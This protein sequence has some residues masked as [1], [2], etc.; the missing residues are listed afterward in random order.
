MRR[1]DQGRRLCT[2]KRSDGQP[3]RAPARHGA[4]VCNAHGGRAPQVIHKAQSRVFEALDPVLASLI[5]MA[6]DSD[7][8]PRDR[9][10]ASRLVLDVA[11]LVGGRSVHDRSEDG[12]VVEIAFPDRHW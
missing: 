4:T 11:G 7:L 1:D 2:A 12:E 6:L 5:D 9:I 10:A 8:S 3:C